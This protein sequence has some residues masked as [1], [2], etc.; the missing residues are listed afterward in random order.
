MPTAKAKNVKKILNNTDL[1]A[2]DFQ[3][4]KV[5]DWLKEKLEEV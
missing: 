3:K 1:K 5:E 4:E 2:K